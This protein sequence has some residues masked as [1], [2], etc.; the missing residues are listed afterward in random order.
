MLIHLF[1]STLKV[2]IVYNPPLF[3]SQRLI[4]FPISACLTVSYMYQA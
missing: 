1:R 3:F 2:R 4:Q